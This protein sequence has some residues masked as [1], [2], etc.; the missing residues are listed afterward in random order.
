MFQFMTVKCHKIILQNK[1]GNKFGRDV[2][3]YY[4]K[5][6]INCCYFHFVVL[7]QTVDRTYIFRCVDITIYLRQLQYHEKIYHLSFNFNNFFK[8]YMYATK[9]NL[10]L[11]SCNQCLT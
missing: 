8:T 5:T 11:I 9:T 1:T 6:T 3:S 7:S 10:T 2:V 4:V